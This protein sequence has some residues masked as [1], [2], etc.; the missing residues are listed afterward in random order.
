[1]LLGHL[2]LYLDFVQRRGLSCCA[3]GQKVG[4]RSVVGAQW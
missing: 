1:M 3:T 2:E 4:V